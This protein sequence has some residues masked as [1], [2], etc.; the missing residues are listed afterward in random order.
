MPKV[1]VSLILFLALGPAALLLLLSLGS[2][3][4]FPEILPDRLHFGPWHSLLVD[5][6]AFAAALATTVSLALPVGLVGTAVGLVC[7][8]ALRGS[9]R[10]GLLRFAVYLPFAL[11]PIIVAV[12]LYDLFARL[13]LAGSY[14]G[15]FLAQLLFATAFGTIFF[16]EFWDARTDVAEHLVAALGGNRR[17]VWRHAVL[18]RA[19][20]LILL[21]FLQTVLISWLDYGLVLFMGGGRVEPLTLRLFGYIREGSVNLAALASLLLLLPALGGL[22][23]VP[24]LLK[25][26][27]DTAS[28][29]MLPY[30]SI[31]KQKIPWHSK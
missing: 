30:E 25:T 5:R 27:S 23:L 8:R 24:F 2:G 29:S 17:A 6:R 11:S 16:S 7:A 3:W 10:P 22:T 9:C 12:C 1:V 26:R 31:E 15:V 4:T 13:G 18:P 19:G 20:G 21:C 28:F 14:T